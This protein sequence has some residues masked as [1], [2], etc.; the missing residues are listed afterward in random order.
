MEALCGKGISFQHRY[1]FAQACCI[2]RILPVSP[3]GLGPELRGQRVGA[4]GN[5]ASQEVS[6]T[7]TWKLPAASTQPGRFR[8][9]SCVWEGDGLRSYE[10]SRCKTSSF[11]DGKTKE[12]QGLA[13]GQMEDQWSSRRQDLEPLSLQMH[14]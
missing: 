6:K 4:A 13:E 8:D 3:Q 2:L 14:G 7:R 9:S 11:I 1:P 12:G 10:P 5:K